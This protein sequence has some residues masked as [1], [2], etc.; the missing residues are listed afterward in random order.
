MKVAVCPR[1]RAAYEVSSPKSFNGLSDEETFK[2]THCRRCDIPSGYFL[3]REDAYAPSSGELG[4]PAAVVPVFEGT[5]ADW[6]LAE[7][8]KVDAF[9]R[10]GLGGWLS[11]QLAMEMRVARQVLNAWIEL[12]RAS[13]P[14]VAQLWTLQPRQAETLLGIARLIGHVEAIVQRSGEPAGFNAARWV[15][16]WLQ[17][18]H[19]ALGARPDRF[20]S[21]GADRQV[22]H[23]L[24]GRIESGAYA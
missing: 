21:S 4:F 1:C 20:L 11:K 12:R 14:V 2:L 13:P 19:P 22:L 5:Y 16:E 24:I 6:W 15:G 3:L 8:N 9:A 18:P 7:P 17:T 10:A 23:D